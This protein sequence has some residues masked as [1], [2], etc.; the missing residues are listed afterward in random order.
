MFLNIKEMEVRR[1]EFDDTGLPQ[2]TA[3]HAVNER[4]TEKARFRGKQ[5]LRFHYTHRDE[6]FVLVRSL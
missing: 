5:K 2:L 1:I 3:I 6:N 4:S